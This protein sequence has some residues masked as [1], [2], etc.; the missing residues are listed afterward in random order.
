MNGRN[1]DVKIGMARGLRNCEDGEIGDEACSRCFIR[2]GQLVESCSML[3]F[4]LGEMI[5]VRNKNGSRN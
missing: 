1:I 5:E 2:S 4:R 3:T